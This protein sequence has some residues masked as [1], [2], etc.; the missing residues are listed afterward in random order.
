MK[1]S[2][3]FATLATM[4]SSFAFMFTVYSGCVMW[5]LREPKMPESMLE[6]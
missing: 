1:K 4:L 3:L 5:V 6:E 2:K